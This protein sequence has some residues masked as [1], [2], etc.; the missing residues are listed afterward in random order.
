MNQVL[1]GYLFKD[2]PKNY[3]YIWMRHDGTP[4]YVGLGRNDRYKNLRRRNAHVLSVVKKMGGIEQVPKELIAVNSWDEGCELEIEL[5]T[6]FG[7]S[8]LK[9]GTLTNKTDGGEGTVNKIVTDKVRNAVRN[10]NKIRIWTDEAKKSVADKRRGFKVTVSTREKLSN[11]FKGKSRPDHV[12]AAMKRGTLLAIK[13]GRHG[14]I[15]TTEHKKHFKEVV[16]E[17]AKEWHAS[18][19]AVKFHKE[20]ANKSWD[21]KKGVE[22]NCHFCGRTFLTPFP[23]RAK[24]CHTNCKQS[25]GLLKK[26]GAVGTRPSRKKP[27][28]PK[29]WD[30][31]KL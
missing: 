30:K 7:R 23:T 17:K 16:Q 13:E 4:F 28:E 10:S 18:E 24:Y 20:I 3:V 2:L 12:I 29:S 5:I 15:N 6:K 26:G 31:K 11:L 8:D 25:A 19:A 27:T 14:W 21:V 22:I 1:I 9:K